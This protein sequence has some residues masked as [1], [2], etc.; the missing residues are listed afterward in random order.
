MPLETTAYAYPFDP[1]GTA[2]SNKITNEVHTI[3]VVNFRDYLFVV[4][5]MAPFFAEQLKLTF[6]DPQGN[7]LPFEEGKDYYLGHHFL[8]ASRA[9]GKQVYGSISLLNRQQAGILRIDYQTLGGMWTYNEAYLLELMTN[10]ISNPRITSWDSIV[11]L[12]ATFPVINHEWDLIDMVGMSDVYNALLAV[13]D[14]LVDP[15]SGGSQL[16]IHVGNKNNPHLVTK[17]QVGLDKVKNY[18][19][20]TPDEAV[21]GLSNTAYLTPA[22]ALALVMN[23]LNTG[24][25]SHADNQENPHH[26]TAAQINAYS[27]DEINNILT[28][29]DQ[30]LT[31]KLDTSGTASDS[32]KLAGMTVQEL[33]DIILQGKAADSNKLSGLTMEDVRIS[34]LQGKAADSDK[35]EGKSLNEVLE[36]ANLIDAKNSLKFN[37][38]TEAQFMVAIG[39]KADVV[40]QVINPPAVAVDGAINVWTRLYDL[41]TTAR[42]DTVLLVGGGDASATEDPTLFMVFVSVIPG[43][44][45]PLRM[46]VLNMEHNLPDCQF[47]Y[48]QH[49][50]YDTGVLVKSEYRI[51]LKTKTERNRISVID[52]IRGTGTLVVGDPTFGNDGVTPGNYNNVT[53]IEPHDVTYVNETFQVRDSEKFSGKTLTEV[54][55]MVAG[56]T[57]TDSGKLGGQLPAFYATAQALT[58]TQTDLTAAKDRI[59]TL[60]NA[61]TALTNRVSTLETQMDQLLTQM[62]AAFGG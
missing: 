42:Q 48:H 53:D 17:A 16:A 58:Q 13:A 27:K 61:N 46:R 15:D 4:P 56:A 18:D 1:T 31:G 37:G 35:L 41:D 36:Q 45:N 40:R 28:Q 20:A 24:I 12:P 34:I 57:V 21:A 62:A 10:I 2:P 7:L 55:Q 3:T 33:A 38:K 49:D 26:V 47:C 22:L 50:T 60:E 9:I 23:R 51:W 44:P 8:A 25:A 54:M 43:D 30:I 19:I 39:E 5:K 52:L 14:A 32:E 11:D 6:T 59:T 29:L